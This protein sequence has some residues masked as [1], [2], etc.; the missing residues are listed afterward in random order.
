MTVD[1]R[2]RPL[3]KRELEES[4]YCTISVPDKETVIISTEYV[5]NDK[6]KYYFKGEKK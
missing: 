1:L 2:T 4:K 6:G 3:L 5:S